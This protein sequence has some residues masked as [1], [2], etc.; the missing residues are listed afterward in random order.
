MGMKSNG[1]LE[2]I[3]KICF[4][5]NQILIFLDYILDQVYAV[6]MEPAIFCCIVKNFCPHTLK[7]L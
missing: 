4:K 5:M 2:S 6:V 3:M 1:I 7:F